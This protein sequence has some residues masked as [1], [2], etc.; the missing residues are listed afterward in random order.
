MEISEQDFFLEEL[1][2]L[3]RETWE[4]IHTDMDG[5]FSGNWSYGCN[6]Q[7]P[8]TVLPN[9]Y[10]HQASSTPLEQDFNFNFNFN[11]NFNGVYCPFGDELSATQLTDSSMNTLDTPPFPIQE[12]FPLSTMDDELVGNFQNLEMQSSSCKVERIHHESPEIPVFNVGTCL[13]GKNRSKKMDGR[14]PSKN[15]MAERRRRKR[16]NDRLS[17]LRS[18]VPKISKVPKSTPFLVGLNKV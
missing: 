10:Y 14:Q 11:C 3:R 17:M 13:E 6:D 15:L 5:S 4:A 1:S 9:S 2:A 7:N 12:D 8:A 18:I 16:L